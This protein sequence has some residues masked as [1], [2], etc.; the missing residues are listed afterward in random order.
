MARVGNPLKKVRTTRII[1]PVI[2]GLGVI[3]FLMFKESRLARLKVDLVKHEIE[4]NW[5]KINEYPSQDTFL[6]SLTDTKLNDLDS[7]P[8]QFKFLHDISDEIVLFTDTLFFHPQ[9]P[10]LTQSTSNKYKIQHTG[11]RSWLIIFE[12]PLE[13]FYKLVRFDYATIFWLF[14]AFV[15]MAFRDLGYIIRLKILADQELTWMQCVKIVFLWEFT[16]A[17]TPSAIGGTSVAILYVNKEGINLGKSSAIV[18]A[19]S[20]LDEIY[21]VIMFPILFILVGDTLF[22]NDLSITNEFFDFAIIGYF[23]KLLWIAFISYGLF[24]N[25]RGFKWILLWIFRLPRIKRWRYQVAQVGTELVNASGELKH[26]SFSFWF[27][28]ILA[29]FFSWTAR[30]WVLNMLLISFF[31]VKVYG[32]QSHLIIFARQ[33][34]M[35]IMMLVSPTP[36]ASGFSEYVFARYLGEFIPIAGFVVIMALTWRLVTYYPYLV[37]GVILLP[38]WI[39]DKFGKKKID[40]IEP[41]ETQPSNQA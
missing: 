36:G 22:M 18:L 12:K 11:P 15:L 33:L 23:F 30:Y 40:Q 38:K 32:L 29:T 39:R 1:F 24:I 6:I 3:I 21:F 17:I 9:N 31:T 37:I 35:W 7:F 41:T 5:Y 25:P 13:S 27:K 26:K 34:A 14:M 19:T 28:A 20:F 8:I 10:S 2:F 16:S 4:D